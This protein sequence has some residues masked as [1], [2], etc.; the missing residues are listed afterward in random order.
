MSKWLRDES[1]DDIG[2]KSGN[3][4]GKEIQIPN[5]Q[6]SNLVRNMEG[7]NAA[8]KVSYDLN[9]AERMKGIRNSNIHDG[10]DN[11]ELNGL[12]LEER[13]RKR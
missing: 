5:F 12:D 9:S 1:S 11:E 13:K 8:N 3:A 7:I 2:E 10:L 4:N 6:S